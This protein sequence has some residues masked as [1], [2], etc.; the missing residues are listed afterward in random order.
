M[1]ASFEVFGHWYG[2]QGPGWLSLGK[3]LSAGGYEVSLA[4]PGAIEVNAL[5]FPLAQ[6]V[7]RLETAPG[8]RVHNVSPIRLGGHSGRRYSFS[9]NH[10]LPLGQGFNLG[11]QEHDVILLGVRHRTIVI[12]KLDTDHEPGVTERVIQ[13]FRFHS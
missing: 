1:K 3:F 13:S 11:P 8:F 2:E 10:L 5:D 4:E 6:T 9:L 12:R 7:R